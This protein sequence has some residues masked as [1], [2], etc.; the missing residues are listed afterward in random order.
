MMYQNLFNNQRDLFRFLEE[1]NKM[2]ENDIKLNIV[3]N[4][5]AGVGAIYERDSKTISVLQSTANKKILIHEFSHVYSSP[6]DLKF[7]F[8]QSFFQYH[9]FKD[10]SFNHYDYHEDK[11][12]D[13]IEFSEIEFKRFVVQFYKQFKSKKD[14]EDLGAYVT[15]L[16][17]TIH[18]RSDLTENTGLDLAG[19]T[20]YH[21]ATA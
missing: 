13:F 9:F 17:N 1:L 3:N 18:S 20:I 10:I 14:F 5:R 12:I 8:I 7:L 19:F 2:T 4:L 11:E 16:V 6:H 15:V 21:R